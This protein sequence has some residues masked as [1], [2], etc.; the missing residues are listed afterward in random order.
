MAC[1][2]SLFLLAVLLLN[3]GTGTGT[4]TR[5]ARPAFYRNS[6]NVQTE[7]ANLAYM[8]PSI[9]THLRSED[10]VH[11]A[12]RLRATTLEMDP[13]APHSSAALICGQH[14]REA[15]TTELCMFVLRQLLSQRQ[16]LERIRNG[17]LSVLLLPLANPQGRDSALEVNPCSRTNPRGVDLNR[18]WPQF[19]NRPAEEEGE[20]HPGPYPL[21]ESE[22]QF[23][24]S[25][26]CHNSSHFGPPDILINVHSGEEAIL[27]AFDGSFVPP[28]NEARL[29]R[30]GN[31][32]SLR[33]GCQDCQ[34]GSGVMNFYSAYGT[35]VDYA[36]K[37]LGVELAF[38][39]EI[40][41]NR[42]AE[43][44]NPRD[45]HHIY[46]PSSASQLH[47]VLQRWSDAF[48]SLLALT[49]QKNK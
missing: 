3:F 49:A 16:H 10:G 5:E 9:S 27:Y 44:A 36:H 37:Q 41:L 8:N 32:L 38:T 31:A 29:A 19:F 30:I 26:I 24:Y 12:F 4:G 23:L 40:F 22:N 13:T 21:S 25:L 20:T 14:G 46:N 7:L 28:Q 18:N 15:I 47:D 48:E 45:C 6:L 2:L 34:V 33:M 39:W 1:L 11:H 17:S 35:L 42:S 43:A